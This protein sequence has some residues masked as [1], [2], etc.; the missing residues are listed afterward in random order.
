[1]RIHVDLTAQEDTSE[2]A[3]VARKTTLLAELNLTHV[4]SDIALSYWI[5]SASITPIAGNNNPLRRALKEALQLLPPATFSSLNLTVDRLVS[6]FPDS[7]SVYTP[8]LL[9][10]S[11]S[12]SSDWK[13]LISHHSSELQS[14]WNRIAAAFSCTHIALNSPIPPANPDSSAHSDDK[15]N[16]LRSPVNITPL[17]GSFGP[18]P[19]SQTLSAPTHKDFA[20][21]LWVSTTQNGIRQTWA[22]LY[23]MFSRGNVKEKARILNLASV[24]SVAGEASNASTSP[25]SAAAA[26]S[27]PA[28][29]TKSNAVG[30]SPT[31]ATAV[32]M[33]AGIG[34][35]SFSY[36][37]AGL[38][39]VLC[40]E[41]NPWSVEGLRRGAALN[42]WSTRV[43][44]AAEVPARD[45][46]LSEWE[47]WRDSA[48]GDV[49]VGSAAGAERGKGV[50]EGGLDFL[51]FA[52]SNEYAGA[53]LACL[54][55]YV[56]PVRHVNLGL[57]PVSRLS[58]PSA[59]GAVDLKY[60][61]WVHAHENVGVVDME[62]RQTE[63]EAEFQ[64]LVNEHGA[65][66]R[67]E[68]R[69]EHVEKVKMYAPGVV[70]AVFDVYIPRTQSD[71]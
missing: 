4:A 25:L 8:L 53:V 68:V 30:A 37:R 10:P 15:D 3:T 44:T 48:G 2:Q 35:F 36:R 11:A 32:D 38:P 41:L 18:V 50:A 31:R 33:Y 46:P 45:A 65:E 56:P 43:F 20:D 52:M 58:W 40:F 28:R 9:L 12:L 13:E 61:G 23:T 63:V 67:K 17:Y 55:D 70:H 62:Q 29:R 26:S 34:Y 1:M 64:R 54:R 66:R 47:A 69:V 59:V 71:T 49:G 39:L 24:R 6:T 14:L 19:T 5:P 7:Y 51:I 57:L 60:G 42:G 27:T 22:P 21:A 16:I